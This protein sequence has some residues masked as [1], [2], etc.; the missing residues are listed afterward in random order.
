LKVVPDVPPDCVILMY[1]PVPT[2]VVVG[3]YQFEVLTPF[4]VAVPS[5]FSTKLAAPL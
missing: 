5:L 1:V 4:S 2:D 3:E